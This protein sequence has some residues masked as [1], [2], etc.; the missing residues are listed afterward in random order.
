V[1]LEKPGTFDDEAS[2]RRLGDER[3]AVARQRKG[4][5]LEPGAVT[6]VLDTDDAATP[7][8]LAVAGA[9]GDHVGRRRAGVVCQA[10]RRTPAGQHHQRQG[11]QPPSRYHRRHHQ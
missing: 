6:Q 1:R 11:K 7:V 4:Q 9:A 3:L 2:L 10:R 5:H 8:H